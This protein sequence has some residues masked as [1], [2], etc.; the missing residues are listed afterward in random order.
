MKDMTAREPNVAAGTEPL[1][2]AFGIPENRERISAFGASANSGRV[3]AHTRPSK[4]KI[5]EHET[6]PR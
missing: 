2:R 4:E 1:G 6:I 5:Q 3:K